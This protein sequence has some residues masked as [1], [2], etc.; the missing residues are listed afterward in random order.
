VVQSKQ[1]NNMIMLPNYKLIGVLFKNQYKPFHKGLLSWSPCLK[2]TF[3]WNRI[4]NEQFIHFT[5]LKYEAPIFG[6][7]TPYLQ[8]F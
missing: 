4:G 6:K 8:P 7:K 2:I 1:E 3:K 5:R